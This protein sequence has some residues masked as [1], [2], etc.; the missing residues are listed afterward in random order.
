MTEHFEAGLRE[1]VVVNAS[2]IAQQGTVDV[3]EICIVLVP[4]QPGA[5][6]DAALMGEHSL[7]S[8]RAGD[9]PMTE[10]GK[11]AGGS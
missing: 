1:G 10:F 11:A 9:D 4:A 8:R 6:S 5:P 3:E 7:K 2:G